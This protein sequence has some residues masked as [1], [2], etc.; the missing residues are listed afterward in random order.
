M[1]SS[2]GAKQ[3][4]I[5][6]CGEIVSGDLE[7]PLQEGDTILVSNG[8]IAAIGWRSD[9]DISN[10]ATIIDARGQG[11]IPG[12]I[13]SHIHQ[14]FG[15]WT[16]RMNAFGWLAAY[17][18]GGVTTALSQGCFHLD[19][20]PS[21]PKGMI[22]LGIALARSF[23]NFRP[24][25]MKV[26]GAAISIV[27]GLQERD[28]EL[29]ATE[30]VSLIAEVGVRSITD[31]H[32]VNL[33]LQEAHRHGFKSRVHFGP[34]TVR[35]SHAVT[36]GMAAIM[37]AHITSHVNGGPTAA[38]R[39]ELDFMLEQTESILELCY[40]GNQK[41]LLYVA[42]RAAELGVLGR[43]IL[44]SDTPTGAGIMPRA[45]LSSIILL[46]AL[47]DV[48]PAKAIAIATGN[49]AKAHGLNTGKLEVGREADILLIDA[50]IGSAATDGLQAIEL[51]DIP[52]ITLLMIDG[53]IISLQTLNTPP[54]KREPRLQSVE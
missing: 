11:A 47:A 19:G 13:D 25:G 30:G 15:D 27:E 22:S 14:V 3:L 17:A 12:L 24:G 52:S 36:A 10:V 33:K 6:S 40:T 48:P 18:Q 46:S 34:E 41:A 29:L 31:P 23:A 1:E 26:H 45:I 28:F 35:G 32:L 21:D 7:H 5:T 44:G 39:A 53:E 2:R 50:P 54:A 8:R 49:N 4:A 16:P 42:Q 43:L 51:G 38:P 20:Y 9:L 37:K